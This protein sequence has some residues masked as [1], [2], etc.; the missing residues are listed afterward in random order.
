MLAT[1]INL[2]ATLVLATS[3]LLDTT[4]ARP[5]QPLQITKTVI[6]FT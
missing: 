3:V 4:L 6:L 2:S 1:T 5:D